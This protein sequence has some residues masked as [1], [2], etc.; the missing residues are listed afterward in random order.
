VLPRGHPSRHTV[1]QHHHA[2][3]ITH[4]PTRTP[5]HT[6]TQHRQHHHDCDPP[7]AARRTIATEVAHRC[8]KPLR[9]L[10]RSEPSPLRRNQNQT[11]LWPSQQQTHRYAPLNPSKRNH[12]STL[13]SPGHAPL[14][15][16]RETPAITERLWTRSDASHHRESICDKEAIASHRRCRI[17]LLKPAEKPETEVHLQKGKR[18]RCRRNRGRATALLE[19][20][21][22]TQPWSW[23]VSADD[24]TT[25]SRAP[26]ENL[27]DRDRCISSDANHNGAVPVMKMKA[28]EEGGTPI[29]N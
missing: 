18:G 22:S 13:V 7:W 15:R 9:D 17:H 27:C 29:E 1:T 19:E 3:T 21:P 10:R 12:G 25:T 5:S 23:I 2:N 6:C 16:R 14:R 11:P 20:P 24:E 26:L 28:L 8:R 4:P